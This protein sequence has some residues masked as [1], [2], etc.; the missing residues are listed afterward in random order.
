MTTR[1]TTE[2]TPEVTTD[3]IP[4]PVEVKRTA[5]L[6][7]LALARQSM[8]DKKRKRDDDIS[9]ITTKLDEISNRL[10][11]QQTKPPETEEIVEPPTEKRQRVTREEDVVEV[12]DTTPITDSWATSIVRTGAILTLG[13]A[14][15]YMQNMYGKTPTTTARKAPEKKKISNKTTTVPPKVQLHS[16]PMQ[17]T[18]VRKMIGGSGFAVS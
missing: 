7:Q 12:E 5:K 4:D 18:R 17:T 6:E 8:R 11:Q 1:D 13:A 14:S 9:S 10:D 2:I 3:V 15:W 16:V